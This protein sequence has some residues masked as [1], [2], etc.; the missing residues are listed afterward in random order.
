MADTPAI[1]RGQEVVP[2]TIHACVYDVA[3][4][5]PEAPAVTDGETSLT[6]GQL[7]SAGRAWTALL[8]RRGMR[9]G[10]VVAVRSTRTTDLPP[11]LLGILGAG[12]CYS[13]IDPDW[14]TGRQAE[15]LRRMAP[16][17]LLSQTGPDLRMRD[18]VPSGTTVIEWASAVTVSESIG[19]RG[20]LAGDPGDAACIFW[21]SG[22]TGAPKGV[23]SPHR[24]TTRLFGPSSPLPGGPG[25]RMLSVASPPWDG[26]S[27]ELW[28]ML[29]TGGCSVMHAG[30]Y[31]L[32]GDLHGAIRRHG[33][34]H[35]FL[36]SGLFDIF[37][38]EDIGCFA[39]LRSLWVGGDRLT[40]AHA[41]AFLKSFP[42]VP[43]VN[44]YG[45]V[46]C[47]VFVTHHH[48]REQDLGLPGGIPVGI[49]VP[50]TEVLILSDG[51]IT[52]R[53]E[54]GEICIAGDGVALGYLHDEQQ[55]A[56][57][58]ATF[59]EP[60]KFGQARCYHTGDQGWMGE[61]GTLHFVGRADRQVKISGHRIE[62]AEIEAAALSLGCEQAMIIPLRGEHGYRGLA[63]FAVPGSHAGSPR[64]LQARLSERLPAQM[65]PWPI[66]FID[67]M[68]LTSTGK[69][70]RDQMEKQLDG[71]GGLEQ[72]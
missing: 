8:L 26:F 56:S 32:P 9:R 17:A 28:S 48:V 37:V 53:G 41:S 49:P 39:G 40:P 50:G 71:D 51:R 33:V 52:A 58:F 7:A 67:H 43:L 2:A 23:L 55:T 57:A 62:P 65:T 15:L 69:I 27:L 30:R 22:S 66:K 61:D 46:E 10:D 19:E 14:P 45:P 59:N 11:I 13:I 20:P 68:P 6:Y 24:A 34:N 36:T 38:A 72:S 60:G 42:E 3:S 47:C 44:G 35:L 18:L 64:E 12:A 31:F 16:A 25:I 29:T 70:D 5:F 63:M 1:N 54:R 4:R 21:T